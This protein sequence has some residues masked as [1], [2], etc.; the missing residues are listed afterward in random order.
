MKIKEKL[1]EYRRVLKTARRPSWQ[2]FKQSA[3]VVGLGMLAIGFMGL[4]INLIFQWV[5][6]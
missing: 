5:G 3:I 4:I 1:S 6:I 2:E